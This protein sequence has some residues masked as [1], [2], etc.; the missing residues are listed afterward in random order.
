MQITAHYHMS[1]LITGLTAFGV[2]LKVG[3]PQKSTL[4]ALSVMDYLG[5]KKGDKLTR[6]QL[7]KEIL[8][9]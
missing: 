9:F 2:I 1:F 5:V 6:E 4:N 8:L 3:M 7:I